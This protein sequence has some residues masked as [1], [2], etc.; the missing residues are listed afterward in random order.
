MKFEY[1]KYAI[2]NVMNRKMRSWLTVLSVLIGI[3]AIYALV[4][5]KKGYFFICFV[6]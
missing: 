5:F 1:L 2:D 6:K 3:T 4:S